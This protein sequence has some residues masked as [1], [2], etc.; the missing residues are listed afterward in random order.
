MLFCFSKMPLRLDCCWQRPLKFWKV[1]NR[2]ALLCYNNQTG[3]WNVSKTAYA[4]E[5]SNATHSLVFLQN[6]V[7]NHALDIPVAIFSCSAS[8]FEF[9]SFAFSSFTS[10]SA[11][12]IVGQLYY[13]ALPGLQRYAS[14]AFRGHCSCTLR[15]QN[16]WH[17]TPSSCSHNIVWQLQC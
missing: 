4:Y 3:T 9:Y 14:I 13:C 6:D 7:S 5:Y 1:N 10:S 15:I 17:F 11:Q 12:C 2:T 8:I 16:A